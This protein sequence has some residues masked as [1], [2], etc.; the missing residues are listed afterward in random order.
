MRGRI[1]AMF[2]TLLRAR[3][4]R[5]VPT[6]TYANEFTAPLVRRSARR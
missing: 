4:R 2:E 3:S 5:T 6:P 1:A